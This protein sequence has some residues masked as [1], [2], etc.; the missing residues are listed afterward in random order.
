MNS[1]KNRSKKIFKSLS[2][3]A[4]LLLFLFN[5]YSLIRKTYFRNLSYKLKHD[6][7]RKKKMV[8]KGEKCIW[9]APFNRSINKSINKTLIIHAIN[10]TPADLIAVMQHFN[11]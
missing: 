2:P 3:N 7:K 9:S 6:G 11:V 10:I 4:T 8:H 1:K 5:F